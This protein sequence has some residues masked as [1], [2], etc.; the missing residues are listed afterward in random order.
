MKSGTHLT[1]DIY[2]EPTDTYNYLNFKSCYPKHTKLN[3]PFN[4]ASKIISIVRSETLQEK[5]LSKLTKRLK[6]QNY[7]DEIITYGISKSQI[8]SSHQT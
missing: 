8:E 6:N 2:S 5:R 4:L 1:T 3:I 7:P